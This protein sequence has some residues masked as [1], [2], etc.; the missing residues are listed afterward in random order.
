MNGQAEP[1]GLAQFLAELRGDGCDGRHAEKILERI[2]A[3]RAAAD[4]AAARVF[5]NGSASKPLSLLTLTDELRDLRCRAI[6]LELAISGACAEGRV[7]AYGEALATLA[8]ELSRGM[9]RFERAFTAELHMIRKD[10]DR[11]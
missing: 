4:A 1:N 3:E 5:F 10:N 9:E 8:T 2:R 7:D 6:T 11:E